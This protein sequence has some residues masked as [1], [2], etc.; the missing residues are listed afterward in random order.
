[1]RRRSNTLASSSDALSEEGGDGGFFFAFITDSTGA[2]TGFAVVGESAGGDF[3]I[4]GQQW[5][6]EKSTLS[7]GVPPY[8]TWYRHITHSIDLSVQL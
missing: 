3:G 7:G 6:S 8:S 4:C 5:R 1:M 2:L